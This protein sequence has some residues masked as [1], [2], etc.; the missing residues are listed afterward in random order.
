[1][2]EAKRKEELLARATAQM[3]AWGERPVRFEVSLPLAML[4]CSS[5]QLALRHPKHP[6]HSS[7]AVRQ[8]VMGFRD[9]I[10]PM[11]DAIRALIERGQHPRF[12][13]IGEAARTCVH[14]GCTD[15]RACAGGCSW[16][17]I[18]ASTPTGVCSSCAGLKMQ[19]MEAARTFDWMQVVLN[20]AAPCF[21]LAEDGRFCGRAEP[22]VGHGDLHEFVPLHALLQGMVEL[23]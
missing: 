9:S 14:C 23:G 16:V 13:G 7:A 3:E 8:C 10:P 11:F 18:H 21:H 5:L 19:L 4:L 17:A 6:P 15:S 12:A 20:Q 2:G 1:M 22:W